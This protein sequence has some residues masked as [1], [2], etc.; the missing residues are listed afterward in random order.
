MIDVLRNEKKYAISLRDFY[1][2]KPRLQTILQ[3]D[4]FDPESR[5]YEVRSLYFDAADEGDLFDVLDGLKNKQKVRLRCYDPAAEKFKMEY[6]CKSGTDSHKFSLSVNREEAKALMAGRYDC[7]YDMNTE[8]SKELYARMISR[9]YQPKVTVVYKRVVY[10]CPL[11][12]VR[13]TFDFDI[14][15]SFNRY[16]LIDPVASYDLISAPASGILEVKYNDFLPGYVRTALGNL[17]SLQVAN[18]KYANARLAF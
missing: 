18:S 12:D 17:D 1:R 10:Q 15:A 7:L 3:P 5:G 16:A 11:N 4:P 2:L 14:K 9:A 6:K 13:I 8:L